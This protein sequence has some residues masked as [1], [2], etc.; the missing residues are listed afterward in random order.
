MAGKRGGKEIL[1]FGISSCE[2]S[3]EREREGEVGKLCQLEDEISPNSSTLRYAHRL[4]TTVHTPTNN[5]KEIPRC[6][7]PLPPFVNFTTPPLLP[8]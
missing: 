6:A 4:I 2:R 3:R 8:G 1:Y 7:T 5:A